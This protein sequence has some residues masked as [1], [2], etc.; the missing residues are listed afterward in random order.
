MHN[1]L[2][3]NWAYNGVVG[4]VVALALYLSVFHKFVQVMSRPD[5][6]IYSILFLLFLVKTMVGGN[7]GFPEPSAIVAIGIALNVYSRI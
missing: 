4:F 6:M 7:A 2:L 5:I 3:S 1:I